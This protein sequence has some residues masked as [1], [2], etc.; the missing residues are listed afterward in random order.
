VKI[1]NLISIMPDIVYTKGPTDA[2]ITSVVYDSRKVSQGCLFVAIKGLAADGHDFIRQAVSGG[3]TAVIGEQDLD[4]PGITYIRVMDSRKALAQSSA[5][6]YGYPSRKLGIIGV[7]GTNGKTTTTYLVKAMLER[8]GYKTGVIGTVGNLIGDKLLH[9]E[10]TTPESLEL[11][12]LFSEMVQHGVKY[13]AMEVS[14]HSLKL[15]RVEGIH[16]EVGVFTNLTQ[17]HMDFHKTFEDYYKSKKKLFDLSAKAVVN[18]D[19]ESGRKILRSID[20]PAFSY[21]ID[22]AA[23]LRARNVKVSPEGV[24]YDVDIRGRSL[25]ISYHVPGKFSVYNSLAALGTGLALGR[26]FQEDLRP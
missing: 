10:G 24:F 19:D 17:D 14:S 20:I 7:T 22:N 11:N 12:L 18:A 15:H 8:A 9:A 23:D 13:V 3:A 25:S 26:V 2:Q 4:L 5:W 21:G 1:G 6:F 16:F